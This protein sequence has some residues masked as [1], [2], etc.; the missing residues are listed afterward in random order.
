LPYRKPLVIF[1]PK[2]LLRHPLCLSPLDDFLEGTHFRE[3]ID[4]DFVHTASV[5]KVL[6]CNGKIYYDLLERQQRNNIRDIAIVRIE[7][8]YPVPKEQLLSIIKSYYKAKQWCWVQEEPENMGA[9]SFFLRTFPEIRKVLETVT[10]EADCS[11]AVGLPKVH[12]A[13][14]KIL[15]R[16]AFEE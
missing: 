8:L 5:R 11:P 2:S 16:R 9:C 3:I 4:D 7:Q 14:Q 6:F 15:V 12:S 10:R 1:T 13:E